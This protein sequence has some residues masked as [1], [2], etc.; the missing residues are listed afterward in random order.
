MSGNG[1]RGDILVIGGGISGLTAAIEAAE[2]GAN[3]TLVEKEAF[4]GGLSLI[5]ISEPTRP[6]KESRMP[7]SA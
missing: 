3:V 4:L 6:M 7:A 5:H 2:A 1:K